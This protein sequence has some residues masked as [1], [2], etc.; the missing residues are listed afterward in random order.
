MN[1][2]QKTRR[3]GVI[4]AALGS[5]APLSEAV[6]K[7][8]PNAKMVH[9]LNEEMLQYVNRNGG[10]DET[11]MRMFARQVFLAE[12]AGVDAI[13]IS[14]NVYA[15]R[16][17]DVRPFVATPIITVDSAMQKQAA[18]I[19]GRIGVLGTNNSSV[20]SCCSGIRKAAAALNLPAPEFADGTVAEAA[21]Y[22]VRGDGATFDSLLVKKAQ[23]LVADGCRAIVL[24]QVTMAR[25]KPALQAAGITVP[26]L[27]SPD[28]CAK[29]VAQMLA[30]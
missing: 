10:V 2:E 13:I 23:A 12:E 17:D 21:E 26:V 8:L 3:I 11:A 22:L 16:V 28:E 9:F 6:Q 30:H 25:A 4:N 1:N 5:A 15:P 7:V 14:C 20:P 29:L 18:L 27:T 19:G 24:A